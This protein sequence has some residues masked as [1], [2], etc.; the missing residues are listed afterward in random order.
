MVCD[1]T[2][3]EWQV[4]K[5]HIETIETGTAHR[6]TVV[7]CSKYA[8]GAVLMVFIA[9]RV[10]IHYS[11]VLVRKTV[12]TRSVLTTHISCALYSTNLCWPLRFFQLSLQLLFST[13]GGIWLPWCVSKEGMWTSKSSAKKVTY[14]Y[15]LS[16]QKH[17]FRVERFHVFLLSS[18]HWLQA[19]AIQ[20][21]KVKLYYHC[22][23]LS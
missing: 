23:S 18:G 15:F 14:M 8:R 21:M 16:V 6:N 3:R 5:P 7:S 12:S 13:L 19:A 20:L 9:H 4:V 2:C 11:S 10:R 22:Q 17:P 1:S